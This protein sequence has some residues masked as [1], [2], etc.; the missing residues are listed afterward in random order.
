MRL[1]ATTDGLQ[2]LTDEML[3]PAAT[4][5]RSWLKRLGA[6][7]GLGM[8]A[9][10]ALA[11][12]R[13]TRQ[14]AGADPFIGE[15]MLF[16]G[17]YQVQGYELCNGQLLSISQNTALFAILGTTYGGNGQTTF[18]LPD[19]RGRFPMHYGT[20]PGLTNH[21]LG[22]FAGAETATLTTAQLPAHTHPLGVA[23]GAGTSNS[24]SGRVPAATVGTAADSGEGVTVNAYAAAANGTAAAA[25]IGTVGGSQ[26][27]SI[28]NPYLALNFQIA[29][30]GLFPSRA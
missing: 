25:A 11:A 17:T 9:G 19:L 14:T 1:L 23:T 21:P 10:P 24:P 7:L 12:P 13:G 28:V 2:S 15:I 30:Q 29:T 27:H 6:A 5:R 20:G 4:A 26:A 22:G 8:L 16:A 18:G 3:H